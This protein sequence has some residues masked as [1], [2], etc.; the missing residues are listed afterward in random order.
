MYDLTIGYVKEFYA[1]FIDYSAGITLRVE[2]EK[3]TDLHTLAKKYLTGKD[4]LEKHVNFVIDERNNEETIFCVGVVDKRRKFYV[5][6]CDKDE[7]LDFPF[8][9]VSEGEEELR[10]KVTILG[11]FEAEFLSDEYN[12]EVFRIITTNRVGEEQ[13]YAVIAQLEN[14]FDLFVVEAFRKVPTEG[15]KRIHFYFDENLLSSQHKLKADV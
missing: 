5:A 14:R 11:S 1:D 6:S 10:R 9:S 13:Y 8:A 12:E 2:E 7:V 4:M 15:A 3:E